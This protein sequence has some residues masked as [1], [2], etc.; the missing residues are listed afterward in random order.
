MKK[1]LLFT[2]T[3]IL[4]NACGPSLEEQLL[5]K[6]LSYDSTKVIRRGEENNYYQNILINT[7][8]I[9]GQDYIVAT[10]REGVCIIPEIK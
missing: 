4:L 10:Y 1:T 6:G 7:V 9:K 5:K 3:V 8:K 2:V